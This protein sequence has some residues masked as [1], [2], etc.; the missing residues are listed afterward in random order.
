MWITLTSLEL[1]KLMLV[2]LDLNILTLP[3]VLRCG[4]PFFLIKSKVKSF[5]KKQSYSY[6]VYDINDE[7]FNCIEDYF[8]YVDDI[9]CWNYSFGIPM[10]D[11]LKEL[12]AEH[13]L[14]FYQ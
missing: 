10:I 5:K 7:D 4:T 2:I 1:W 3:V 6:M 13:L 9:V 12:N 8:D 11:S 14:E